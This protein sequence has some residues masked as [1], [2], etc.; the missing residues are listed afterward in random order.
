MCLMWYNSFLFQL[1]ILLYL[2]SLDASMCVCV[3]V[4]VSVYAHMHTVERNEWKAYTP[5]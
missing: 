4:W 1:A 2:S 5:S 3:C